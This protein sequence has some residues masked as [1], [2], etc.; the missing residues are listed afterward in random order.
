MVLIYLQ[1]NSTIKKNFLIYISNTKIF[2]YNYI[3]IK[4]L[5]YI[6]SDILYYQYSCRI[7]SSDADF[8]VIVKPLYLKCVLLPGFISVPCSIFGY[9]KNDTVYGI[10]YTECCDYYGVQKFNDYSEILYQNPL[11]QMKNSIDLFIKA[12]HNKSIF[13]NK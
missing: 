10:G 9:Y 6:K 12:K 1:F 4:P 2:S 8:D 7:K 3:I 13:Y 5:S 11:D